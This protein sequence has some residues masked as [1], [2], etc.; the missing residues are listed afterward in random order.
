MPVPWTT[1]G[2]I[3]VY[4]ILG[5]HVAAPGVP[6]QEPWKREKSG[7]SLKYFSTIYFPHYLEHQ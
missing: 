7:T 5:H 1:P 2:R 6:R 3:L 4:F